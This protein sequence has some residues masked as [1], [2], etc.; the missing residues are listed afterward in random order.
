MKRHHPATNTRS[1]PESRDSWKVIVETREGVI[2]NVIGILFL[3]S[4]CA[5][6]ITLAVKRDDFI[7][8]VVTP[9]FCLGWL[10]G[11]YIFW[12][13]IRNPKTIILAIDGNRL[14]WVLRQKKSIH[15]EEQGIL[16]CSIAAL[17]FVRKV[18]KY[19][20]SGLNLSSTELLVV[21]VHGQHLS[22]PEELRPDLYRQRIIDAI[23]AANPAVSII[24]RTIRK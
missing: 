16:L 19:T 5:L 24:D 1:N 12:D 6:L 17:E 3:L 21:D 10:F 20:S 22:L 13:N 7:L 15:D 11:C 9:V 4:L 14:V 8:R 2:S 23:L 18:P